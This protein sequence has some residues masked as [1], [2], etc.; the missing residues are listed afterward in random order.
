MALGHSGMAAISLMQLLLQT[1]SRSEAYFR[2]VVKAAQGSSVS[3]RLVVEDEGVTTW[4]RTA[5]GSGGQH[6]ATS[7]GEVER[8][9]HRL[10]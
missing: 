9:G 6:T 10:F 8:A 1:E 3:M 5:S 2:R 7:T 4:A